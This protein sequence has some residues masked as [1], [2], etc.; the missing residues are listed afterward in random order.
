MFQD[1]RE[2]TQQAMSRQGDPIPAQLARAQG[3]TQ[4][5]LGRGPLQSYREGSNVHNLLAGTTRERRHPY[6]IAGQAEPGLEP[7]KV[8]YR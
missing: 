5:M 3:R 7:E 4:Q 2:E 6:R 1:H 8:S